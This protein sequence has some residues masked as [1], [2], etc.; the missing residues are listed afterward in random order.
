MAANKAL[1]YQSPLQFPV[2]VTPASGNTPASSPITSGMPVVLQ[3]SARGVGGKLLGV[4]LVANEDAVN[5]TGGVA[6]GNMCS[7][8]AWGAFWLTVVAESAES[9]IVAV[10]IKPGD[11]IFANITSGTFDATTGIRYGMTL[12]ANPYGILFGFAIDAIASGLTAS[13]RVMLRG[14]VI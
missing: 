6:P 10:A 5:P 9:P 12:D 14:A 7:F 4:A 13:I 3:G 8:D 1:E 2:P 11:P